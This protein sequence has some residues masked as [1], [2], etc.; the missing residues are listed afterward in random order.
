MSTEITLDSFSILLKRFNK[1]V[2]SFPKVDD[3]K[4]DLESI[5]EDAIKAVD[6]TGRQREAVVARVNN[7]LDGTYAS[8]SRFNTAKV[9]QQK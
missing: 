8:T 6:L 1:L 7:Y 9:H 3:I 2:Q 4:T 5:K